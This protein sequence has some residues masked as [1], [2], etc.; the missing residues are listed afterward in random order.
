MLP[1]IGKWDV[2]IY[3]S[4]VTARL[5]TRQLG[6]SPHLLR[7]LQIGEVSRLPTADDV[8]AL[9]A[10]HCPGAVILL[11]GLQDGRRVVSRTDMCSRDELTTPDQRHAVDAASY[12]RFSIPT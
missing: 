3:C 8:I 6:L 1:L 4:A 11:F 12:R 7:V 9:D 5:V 2:P 10:N